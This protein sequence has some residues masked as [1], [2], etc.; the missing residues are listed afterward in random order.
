MR[1]LL[2]QDQATDLVKEEEVEEGW[3][4]GRME[5]SPLNFFSLRWLKA[6]KANQHSFAA[7][8]YDRLVLDVI[9]VGQ[10]VAFHVI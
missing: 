3:M 8:F 4:E 9:Q 7:C 5:P 1:C 10:V 2:V 6:L